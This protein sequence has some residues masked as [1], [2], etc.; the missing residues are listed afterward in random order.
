MLHL[1]SKTI[2][3]SRH[4][5]QSHLVKVEHKVQFTHIVKI[6]IQHLQRE[7]AGKTSGE[8][9]VLIETS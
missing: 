5:K 6:F 3:K 1:G 2:T 8:I 9:N 7:E 4:E